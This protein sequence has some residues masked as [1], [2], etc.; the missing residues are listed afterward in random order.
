[1][2]EIRRACGI[3][4]LLV[5]ASA[6][7]GS[8]CSISGARGMRRPEASH[9]IIAPTPLMVS[10]ARGLPPHLAS[11][12]P[13]P[14]WT[15]IGRIP[16]GWFWWKEKTKREMRRVRDAFRPPLPYGQIVRIER[17][18]GAG[19]RRLRTVLPRNG[20]EAVLVFWA[21]GSSCGTELSTRREPRITQTPRAFLRAELRGKR[22]WVDGRPTF[23]VAAY[24]FPY[25]DREPWPDETRRRVPGIPATEYW[26]LYQALP[27]PDAL[28]RDTAAA[29]APLR[30]WVRSRP[31][32]ARHPVILAEVDQAR[33][34]SERAANGS[35]P[36]TSAR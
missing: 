35:L 9:L 34:W 27:T 11:L 21:L 29:L 25:R 3:A 16:G 30:S 12:P 5:A 10:A 24:E 32:L 19:S 36:R 1:M 15:D 13:E 2:G 7:A 28:R 18:G 23:D 31:A 20:G 14:H 8:A 17:I 22:G 4:L 6:D 26:S 33:N